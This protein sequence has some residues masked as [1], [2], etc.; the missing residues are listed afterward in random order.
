MIFYYESGRGLRKEGRGQRNEQ[1][2][3]ENFLNNRYH[4]QE[5]NLQKNI[6]KESHK[7]NSEDFSQGKFQ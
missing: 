6:T 5:L 1:K 4:C 7:L 3:L 2:T